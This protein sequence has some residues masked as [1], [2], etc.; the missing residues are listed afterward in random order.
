MR[1]MNHLVST[2]TGLI[3]RSIALGITLGTASGIQL[4]W[5]FLRSLRMTSTTPRVVDVFP[6]ID[7]E[8]DTPRSKE[9]KEQNGKDAL[10]EDGESAPVLGRKTIHASRKVSDYRSLLVFLLWFITFLLFQPTSA[11]D[12]C[13]IF[14]ELPRN[15]ARLVP[16]GPES[17]PP[18]TSTSV[19]F[20]CETMIKTQQPT[21]PL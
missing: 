7:M 10:M 14:L 12:Q 21:I 9:V 3:F 15:W 2:M 18:E 1:Y 6:N 8:K 5:P 19:L 20:L 4:K 17:T 16:P 13:N 11:E